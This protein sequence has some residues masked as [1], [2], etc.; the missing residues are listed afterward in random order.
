[1]ITWVLSVVK[2]FTAKP[3]IIYTMNEK[4]EQESL[5]EQNVNEI[6]KAVSVWDTVVKLQ[7]ALAGFQVYFDDVKAA[8]AG[9]LASLKLLEYDLTWSAEYRDMV[10]KDFADREKTHKA[11]QDYWERKL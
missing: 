4:T 3:Y 6:G 10:R 7:N 8:K 5:N 11:E 1:M 9:R 2:L